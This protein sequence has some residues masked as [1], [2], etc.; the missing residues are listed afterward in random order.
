[1]MQIFFP[2]TATAVLSA[3]IGILLH[4]GAVRAA[5][6]MQLAV[7]QPLNNLDHVNKQF[8][9]LG[10]FHVDGG[11]LEA[12]AQGAT[13]N[14]T[15]ELPETYKDLVLAFD[16]RMNERQTTY[17]V[18]ACRQHHGP[19]GDQ[20]YLF[21]FHPGGEM[22]LRKYDRDSAGKT[23]VKEIARST[24][25]LVTGV[26][27]RI[28]LAVEGNHLRVKV[29]KI[30]APEPAQWSISAQDDTYTQAGSVLLEIQR[31]A[32]SN[33]Q[34]SVSLGNLKLWRS[35]G[36]VAAE[37]AAADN[38]PPSSGDKS[39][40]I[41]YP[42]LAVT[43]PDSARMPDIKRSFRMTEFLGGD[44]LTLGEAE[45]W[46]V[47][48]KK[49]GFNVLLTPYK[50]RYLFFDNDQQTRTYFPYHPSYESFIKI[51][52]TEVQAAHKYG[53]KFFAHL[54]ATTVE[55]EFIE[56]HP[57]W[58]SIDIPTGK[59]PMNSYGSY[60]TCINNDAFMAEYFRRLKRFLKETG[61]DGIMQDEIQFMGVDLCGCPS[62]RAKY[63]KDVGL[64]YP[65]ITKDWVW[66]YHMQDPQYQRWLQWRRQ[67][68]VDRLKEYRQ[69]VKS[70]NPSIVIT[71]YL[72]SNVVASIY[73]YS[74]GVLN[75]YPQFAD[76]I[77]Y[78]SEPPVNRNHL[79][80]YYRPWIIPQMKYMAAVRDRMDSGMWTYFY[81]KTLG[82]YTW[83]WMLA[84]SQNSRLWWN[85][86]HATQ[87]A[88]GPLVAWEANHDPILSGQRTLA[89]VG[90]L[91]STK[92]RDR[93]TYMKSEP[94]FVPGFLALCD[95]LSDG[96]VP[97]RVVVEEDL[98]DK[99]PLAGVKVLWLPNVRV[100]S[101]A[102]AGVIR[103]FVHDGGT[104]L[105]T[106][107][108][109]LANDQGDLQ[110]NFALADLF[111]CDYAGEH[112][113][114]GRLGGKFTGELDY[115]ETFALVKNIRPDVQILA[116]LKTG[117]GREVPGILARKVG[118]GHVIY[119]A[120]RPEAEYVYPGDPIEPGKDWTDHRNPKYQ[121]LIGR[122]TQRDN[123]Q[124]PLVADNLPRGVV[125][126]VYR[127]QSDL[128]H[129]TVVHVVNFLGGLLKNGPVPAVP[130][131]TY[132][133]VKPR[134]PDPGKPITLSVLA[135]QASSVLLFSPDFDAVVKL[136]FQRDGEYIRVTLPVFYRYFM[137]YVSDG[138]ATPLLKRLGVQ[139]TVDAIPEAKKLVFREIKPLAGDGGPGDHI[140]LADSKQMSGGYKANIQDRP[141]Q[142]VYGAQSGYSKLD[143]LFTLAKKPEQAELEIG[144]MD[145]NYPPQV[146]IEIKVNGQVIYAGDSGFPDN[147]WA[148]RTF[149]IKPDVLTSGVNR[150]EIINPAPGAALAPPW[151]G[152]NF[153]KIKTAPNQ[154]K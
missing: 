101:E 93:I 81:P 75:D 14:A 151:V 113:A 108:T 45:Q 47:N 48:Y 115:G 114:P 10:Q 89:N 53:M 148:V 46:V 64:P 9:L 28:K 131:I 152:I 5:G 109:S 8:R 22:Y 38:P 78:E 112:A 105:A 31:D 56:A 23:F 39:I 149:A 106:G 54:T 103:K 40:L 122:L 146:R 73:P 12:Q 42:P 4:C 41:G 147:Q 94:R 50:N 32:G 154:G 66:E 137:L 36:Q 15:L 63:Q 123:P 79:Y 19:D 17:L 58:A 86:T 29:W 99:S 139:A 1:M 96:Q 80:A 120:A 88:W 21:Y 18:V 69:V 124:P 61:V 6:P 3:L 2:R 11:M 100:L 82:D 134:L 76:Q 85:A 145:D 87:G 30:P 57:D 98:A 118:A 65:V 117:E 119:C 35:Q 132:P 67:C 25:P 111:G 13:T 7:D 121:E 135:P 43:I 129:G 74:G 125:T 51:T 116:T 24:S 71:N 60:M 68:V 84:M 83:T 140:V 44:K 59:I 91:F 37:S 70:V 141:G 104:L 127:Y 26:T 97:Y 52:R 110:E 102:E 62:C 107:R 143:A 34:Y 55:K 142:W 16:A 126:E 90:V 77:G 133:E 33:N 49:Q 138:D 153:I 20:G 150:V 128:G 130:R 95:A 92:D 27:C 144:G 136:P 72:S